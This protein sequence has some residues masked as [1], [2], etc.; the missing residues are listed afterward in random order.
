ML[1]N[2]SNGRLLIT[3]FD[4]QSFGHVQDAPPHLQQ[5]RFTHFNLI[6]HR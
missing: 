5:M 1:Y 4:E 6:F 2:Q 3:I